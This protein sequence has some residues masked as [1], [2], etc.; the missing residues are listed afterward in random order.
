M[1]ILF[2]IKAQTTGGSAKRLYFDA[3][4]GTYG[5]NGTHI[6]QVDSP[7]GKSD[8]VTPVNYAVKFFIAY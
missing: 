6:E 3:S 8:H 4:Y 5:E 7:Y 2:L 1:K